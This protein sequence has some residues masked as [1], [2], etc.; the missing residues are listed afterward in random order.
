MV[1]VSLTVLPIYIATTPYDPTLSIFMIFD[2]TE[3]VIYFV[4]GML[5]LIQSSDYSSW[6]TV[7]SDRLFVNEF[8]KLAMYIV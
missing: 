1:N 3:Q 7:A 6:A 5:R 4:C 8:N 2:I